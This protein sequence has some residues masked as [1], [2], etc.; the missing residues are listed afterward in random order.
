MLCKSRIIQ[1]SSG[2]NVRKSRGVQ[3]LPGDVIQTVQRIILIRESIFPER[4]T[5]DHERRDVMCPVPCTV[6]KYFPSQSGGAD[7]QG[8]Y[9]KS[10]RL[11]E[12]LNLTVLAVTLSRR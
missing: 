10:S 7:L 6:G 11:R 8:V 3:I 1:I 2:K 5:A 12:A 9:S 4:P